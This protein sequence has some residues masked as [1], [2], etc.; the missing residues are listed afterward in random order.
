MKAYSMTQPKLVEEFADLEPFSEWALT[1][2]NE[3]Y[4]HRRQQSPEALRAFY[5]AMMPRIDAILARVDEYPIGGLPEELHSIYY[6]ALSLAEIAPNIELY[7]GSPGV[8]FAFDESRFIAAHGN[9]DA[10]LGLSPSAV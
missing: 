3:R 10:A 1:T 8:P 2:A 7:A 9:Q 6:M 4:D 5:D